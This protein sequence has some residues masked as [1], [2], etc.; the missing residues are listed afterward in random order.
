LWHNVEATVGQLPGDLLALRRRLLSRAPLSRTAARLS[1]VALVVILV[2]CHSA[3]QGHLSKRSEVWCGQSLTKP[4]FIA[5]YG[6][7]A[8]E[9]IESPVAAAPR[10]SVL[11]P[12][13]DSDSP[14][15]LGWSD[16][17]V[18]SKD[19]GVGLVVTVSQSPYVRTVGVAYD[20]NGWCPTFRGWHGCPSANAARR[21]AA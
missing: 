21:M 4:G 18:L 12:H 1:T 8:L 10:N 13:I 6:M 16:L 7:R 2:G 11:P 14:E 5:S 9:P 15:L 3:S 19:C 17:L 20:M